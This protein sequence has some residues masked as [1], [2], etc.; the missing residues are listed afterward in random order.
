MK[1]L[2]LMSS[3]YLFFI[4]FCAN[5]QE[6]KIV[7]TN[8]S[9][10]AISVKSSENTVSD[11][12]K[13]LQTN[14]A[15]LNFKMEGN[16]AG[17]GDYTKAD[18]VTQIFYKGKEV[19]KT[20]QKGMPISTGDNAVSLTHFQVEKLLVEAFEKQS[21]PTNNMK[22]RTIE[23]TKASL[24]D[25]LPSTE[26]KGFTRRQIGRI[27]KDQYEVRLSIYPENN[28]GATQ[29]VVFLVNII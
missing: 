22:G 27:P 1:T 28:P 23:S 9:Q 8:L 7:N 29:S 15:K 19:G 11:I 17:T 24:K 18:L 26:S 12:I 20:V 25:K 10:K 21:T 16:K 4:L 3:F 13:Q 14:P 6:L 2:K 5:A